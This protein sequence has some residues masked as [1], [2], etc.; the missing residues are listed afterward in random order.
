MKFDYNWD[1][2]SIVEFLNIFQQVK[3][4]DSVVSKLQF[5]KAREAEVAWIDA[6]LGITKVKT[7]TSAMEVDGG[8]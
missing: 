4:K 5:F 7:E 8:L 1:F 3:L 6:R 2:T